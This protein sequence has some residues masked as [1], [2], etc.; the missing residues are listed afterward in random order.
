MRLYLEECILKL[1]GAYFDAEF[2]LN[3]GLKMLMDCS[4]LTDSL[5]LC[6][7]L[8]KIVAIGLLNCVMAAK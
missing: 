2:C 7:I 5:T 1:K 8:P 6:S 3:L 4:L